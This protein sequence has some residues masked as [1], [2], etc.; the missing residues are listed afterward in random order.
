MKLYLDDERDTP[1]GWIRAYTAQE[2]IQILNDN[3]VEEISLDH[4]LGDD[5]I[6]GTGYDVLLWIENEIRRWN[7][8]EYVPPKKIH[9]HT[10]NSSARIK[11][12]LALKSI[13]KYLNDEKEKNKES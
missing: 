12:E 1:S 4:D 6:H 3:Y 8:N 11:M 13:E 5:F 2:A 9:I 10:S 7:Y